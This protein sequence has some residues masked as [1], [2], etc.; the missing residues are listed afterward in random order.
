MNQQQQ[1]P[2]PLSV[3]CSHCEA[4]AD[5][6]CVRAFGAHKGQ[7]LRYGGKPDFHQTRLDFTWRK[8]RQR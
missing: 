8:E 7:P 6:P 4:M 1:D 3:M 5:M 2:D